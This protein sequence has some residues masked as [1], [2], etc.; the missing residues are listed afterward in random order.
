METE[1]PSPLMLMKRSKRVLEFDDDGK[2]IHPLWENLSRGLKKRER[3][4][5]LWGANYNS[6]S[7][8]LC[9]NHI[10]LAKKNAGHW[11]L[12][13]GFA[14]HNEK[15]LDCAIRELCEEIFSHQMIKAKKILKSCKPVL[16]YTNLNNFDKMISS[17]F[18]I[19]LNI[20]KFDLKNDMF[21]TLEK[22]T[23]SSDDVIEAKWFHI[24]QLPSKIY[25][26]H[27]IIIAKNLHL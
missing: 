14:K 19:E 15:H 20:F 13:G 5:W 10:L 22:M 18:W 11:V 27:M 4:L 3:Q 17:N 12:P 25:P 24:H 21:D 9:N 2:P 8:L 6:C 16:I 1:V 26:L 7:L 23:T